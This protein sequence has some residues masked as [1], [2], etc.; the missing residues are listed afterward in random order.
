VT[1]QEA[2]RQIF[3]AYRGEITQAGQLL[4]EGARF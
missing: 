2:L 1:M 4:E 3:D